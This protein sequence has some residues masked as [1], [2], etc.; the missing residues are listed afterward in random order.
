VGRLLAGRDILNVCGELN[1]IAHHDDSFTQG[2]NRNVFGAA[3]YASAIVNLIR[4]GAHLEMRWT[5]TSKRWNAVDDAYGLMSVHGEPTAA[6]LAKQLFAQ[7]VR[8]GD[9][10]QFPDIE[11]AHPGIDAIIARNDAGRRSAVLVNTLPRTS[12]WTC[13]GGPGTWRRGTR[14]MQRCVAARLRDWRKDRSR[15]LP[16]ECPD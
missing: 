5:A 10:I 16:G 12:R 7:H 15:A 3:Y 1:T 14:R 4:G 8:Y 11:T 13:L 2:L 9:W 6:C